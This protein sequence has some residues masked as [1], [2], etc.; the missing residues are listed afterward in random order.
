MPSKRK[1]DLL[2]VHCSATFADMDIGA[3]EIRKW[4]V[5]DRGW[6][7]IGYHFVIRR[8]GTVEKGRK[9]YRQGAHAFGY[10][11]HSLGICMVGG[12]DQRGKS[13]GN[14]TSPQYY[15]LAKLL[16]TLVKKYDL[17]QSAI[18]GHR[19]LS[20]DKN[21]DGKV[22]EDEWLKQCPSFEVQ[23]FLVEFGKVL[24]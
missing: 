21:K 17:P 13:A 15:A 4:H 12:V 16:A 6:S 24:A 3:S 20:P 8:D 9:E 7:D 14:F 18:V 19:D 11:K 23:E 22:T 10:N 1:I 2:V 5:E